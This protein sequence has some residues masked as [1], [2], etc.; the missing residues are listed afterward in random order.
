MAVAGPAEGMRNGCTLYSPGKSHLPPQP[1][2]LLQPAPTSEA[3][4]V[5]AA[6]SMKAAD[7]VV[8]AVAVAAVVA[9]VA[10]AEGVE[11]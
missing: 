9:A 10:M 3:V 8:E 2:L 11:Q 7:V 5:M 4:A 1:L 6:V